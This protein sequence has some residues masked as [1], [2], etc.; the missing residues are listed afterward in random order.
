MIHSAH[1]LDRIQREKYRIL[2]QRK[3]GSLTPKE[4]LGKSM[5]RMRKQESTNKQ[6]VK[7][8][9]PEDLESALLSFTLKKN[10]DLKKASDYYES[11]IKLNSK[12][13]GLIIE[14][15]RFLEYW[16]ELDSADK[17]FLSA[18]N[19]DP[20]HK[21]ALKY[22]GEFLTHKRKSSSGD[23]FRKRYE[24]IDKITSKKKTFFFN[25]FFF[26]TKNKEIVKKWKN[27]EYGTEEAQ[28][29]INEIT[30]G[31]ATKNSNVVKQRKNLK[32]AKISMNISEN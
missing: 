28:Q 29:L 12:N 7:E 6:E 23:L 24:A 4:K 18:L 17:F 21:E 31:F 19:I 11:V 22:Y 3:R 13:V 1:M 2:F 20:N 5:E 16:S 9:K 14:Y 27:N 8:E 15:A 25:F 10:R 30:K 32:E 26:L